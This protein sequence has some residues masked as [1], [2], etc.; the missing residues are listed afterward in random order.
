M[1]SSTKEHWN[2]V[3][4]S[5]S[6]KQLGWYEA[7]PE[8]SLK[9]IKNCLIDRDDP[10]LDIGAGAT[11]LIDCLIEQNY[12]NITA[13]DISEVALQVLRMRL[14][15]E[16]ASLVQMLVDD[17]T[18]PTAV[19]ELQDIA[20]WHDRALLHFLTEDVQRQVYLSVLKKVLRSEGYVII[21]AF[22]KHGAS[23]CSGLNVERYDT[24]SLAALLGGEFELKESVDYQYQMLSGDVRPYVYSRFQRKVEP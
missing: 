2:N 6:V 5:G 4:S 22:A 10:I 20:I 14:G 13:M 15:S 21:A 7:E 23:K 11:T 16:K 19:L 9:M 1:S 3:Y 12:E 8:V 24:K 18:N 17:V